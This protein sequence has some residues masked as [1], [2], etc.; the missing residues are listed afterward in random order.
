MKNSWAEPTGVS[1]SGHKSE[2][3]QIDGGR[4][5]GQSEQNKQQCEDDVARSALQLVLRL[6]CHVVAETDRIH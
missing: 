3:E 2:H 6:Q 4:E 5:N 1:I